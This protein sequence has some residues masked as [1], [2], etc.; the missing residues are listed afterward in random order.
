MAIGEFLI[1][2]LHLILV[3]ENNLCQFLD[4]ADTSCGMPQDSMLGPL[5]FLVNI[6][7]L[8]GAIKYCKV[9]HFADDTNVMKFQDFVKTNNTQINHDLKILTYTI[10]T[11]SSLSLTPPLQ[12][13]RH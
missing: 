7:D 8:H 5:L 10:H 11:N 6:N 9:H 13:L 1:N 4:S 2:C 12:T 3:I